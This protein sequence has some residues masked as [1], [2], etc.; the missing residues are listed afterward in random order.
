MDAVALEGE[1]D[2][3][4]HEASAHSNLDVPAS[5]L[6]GTCR[7][8]GH[9]HRRTWVLAEG[10][11]C[12]LCQSSSPDSCS[13]RWASVPGGREALQGRPPW[14]ETQAPLQ[15]ASP[16][17]FPCQLAAHSPHPVVTPASGP[18]HLPP[19]AWNTLLLPASPLSFLAWLKPHNL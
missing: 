4:P 7:L 16:L 10:A 18:L 13:L 19:T 2:S 12:P 9:S 14:A 17:H 3:E 5:C 11:L 15:Q 8:W 1:W 6:Q